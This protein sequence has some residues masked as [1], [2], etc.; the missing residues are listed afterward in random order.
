[1][2]TMID[3][4]DDLLVAARSA[5]GTRTK[6]DTVNAALAEVVAIR[7]RRAAV[8]H[9]VSG[10]LPDLGNPEVMTAAWR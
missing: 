1:M 3:L 7:G 8:E 9:L 10:N 2:K 5:L 4:D 6:K